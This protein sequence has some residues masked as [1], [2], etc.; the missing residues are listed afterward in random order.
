M[1]KK[2]KVFLKTTKY[3]SNHYDKLIKKFGHNVRSSQQSSKITRDE[4]GLHDIQRLEA[5]RHEIRYRL[6]PDKEIKNLKT[7]KAHHQFF[8]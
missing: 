8:G 1:K 7:L 2:N 5:G 6:S 4:F 3:L